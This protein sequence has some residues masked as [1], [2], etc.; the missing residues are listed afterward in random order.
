MRVTIAPSKAVGSVKAPPS[1]SIA[2][3][4][5]IC[6]A[7]TNGCVVQNC[8]NSLDV[9]ATMRCLQAMGASVEVCADTVKIGGLNPASLPEGLVL[10]CG[11]SAST[12][13]FLLPLCLISG[14][15]VAFI[16]RGRLMQRPMGVYEDLCRQHD[17]LFEQ[18]A[19]TITVRGKLQSGTFSI[20]GNVSSQFATGLLFALSHLSGQSRVEIAGPFE[21]ASYVDLTISVMSAFGVCVK[22][23]G[24]GF[25]VEGN[26]QFFCPHYQVEGDYSNAAY[27]D[28]LN[29]SGGDVK[30]FG[31]SPETPQ[32]DRVY[33]K[34]YDDLKSGNR[35]FDLSDCPDLGPIMFA[36]S[37]LHNGAKFIGTDRLKMKE[38]DR[39]RSM[40]EELSKFGIIAES[41]KNCVEIL[42]GELKTPS[43]ILSGHGDHRVVMALSLLCSVVGGTIDGAEAVTKSFP[44]YFDELR[45]LGIDL[46]VGDL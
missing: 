32:G 39:C 15:K 29:L 21:S 28:A 5:L 12:L 26:Q 2:H 8:G 6:G 14:K 31:L 44:G 16:G 35:K 25:V 10:D 38:S 18:D 4:A 17:Y 33:K 43:A 13:R 9:Q 40:A 27:L 45:S 46:Q 3:R 22:R 11:E 24:N 19:N 36:L 34:F 1:K 30:V 41:G 20:P 23:E 37:A 42:S 7:L